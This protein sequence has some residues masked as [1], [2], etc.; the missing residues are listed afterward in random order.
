MTAMVHLD[1]QN[2]LIFT[3]VFLFPTLFLFVFFFFKEPKKSFDLPPSPPSLPI[4]GHL[5][6]IISSSMHK[7]FQKISSKYGQFLHL[8]IFHVPIVLVSSPTVAYEIFKAHDTNVSYRGPIAIDECIV[9]GSSGYIRAPS[10]DYWRFMKKIIMAKALGPQAL[11]RTRGVRL[12]ELERFHR[13]LLDKAMK[14]ESVEVGEEAMRLVNNTLGKMS[15]GSSFSVEDNDGGK[16]C[17]LSVAFT[18]LCHKFCVAQVFHKPL[19]KLGISFLKKDVMEVS[20]RF[21]EHLEK[22]LAKYEEK[23]EEHQG[24]EFMDA[25]LE[26]YQG[27]TAEYKMTRK[28]IKALFAELFV[29]AGDSSSST[30]RWAMAEIINNPKILE[31]LREEIDSVVGKNRLVQ[32]TDLTNLPYLQ[33]VV[34]EALRLHPVGAVVPREF[35]EGCTIGGFYIPEG[36][37]LAVNSYAIM[38]DPDSWED[39]CKFKPERFLTSSRSWKEEERKEQALKFLAFGAGRRGCPGSNLGSTFVGTAVGVMVQ[40]FDWEIEGDKVNMEEASGLRFFMALAKPLKCTPS[41]RNMNHLPS[42][43]R[44]QDYTRFQLA[45]I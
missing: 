17:E 16:V 38:R 30:T 15:M 6:L 40:C 7:C 24:A 4:I 5:H 14:K 11:E 23:V 28:Q 1:I 13:N 44:G 29:G 18:S 12:V 36:T 37:S 32:E 25:L 8:R 9:F 19:E 42:D 45:N 31:R 10:G 22:I 41:P 2:C 3:L 34:K 21:E 43:S 39:P 35:Q 20:H 27:E 33:A 26:S